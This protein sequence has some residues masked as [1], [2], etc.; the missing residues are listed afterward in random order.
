MSVQDKS[1]QYSTQT[2]AKW[3]Y[4][5]LLILGSVMVVGGIAGVIVL[6]KGQPNERIDRICRV[7]FIQIVWIFISSQGRYAYLW[8]N[9]K[10]LNDLGYNGR[11]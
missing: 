3:W 7:D 4:W 10:K 11:Y 9:T 2:K 8:A 1:I 6:Q 5:P